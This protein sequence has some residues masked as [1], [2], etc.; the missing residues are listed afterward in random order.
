MNARRKK[1]NADEGRAASTQS[2]VYLLSNQNDDGSW[3]VGVCDD[4]NELGFAPETYYAWQQAACGLATMSMLEAP[5]TEDVNATLTRAIDW[6]CTSRPART[7]ERI[8]MWIR[9][10]RRSTASRPW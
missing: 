1:L 4:I 5:R 3:A 10:G 2:L 6:L 8:G 7:A 9:P